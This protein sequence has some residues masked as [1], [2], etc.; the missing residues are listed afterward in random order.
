MAAAITTAKPDVIRVSKM[1]TW[2]TGNHEN[3]L[4]TLT[5]A[6]MRA[7]DRVRQ[8]NNS[9]TPTAMVSTATTQSSHPKSRLSAK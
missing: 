3:M 1:P 5:T 2:E 8:P 9:K 6:A 4:T 7:A